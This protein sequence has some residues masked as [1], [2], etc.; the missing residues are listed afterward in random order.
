M[1]GNLLNICCNLLEVLYDKLLIDNEVL[2]QLDCFNLAN[3][4]D[5]I[6]SGL[7]LLYENSKI[8]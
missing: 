7:Y 4:V 1:G 6:K 5:E 8:I 2:N 3:P